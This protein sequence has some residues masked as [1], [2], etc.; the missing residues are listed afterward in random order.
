[1]SPSPV[2]STPILRTALVWSAIV[3]GV[4]AVILAVV[5]YLVGGTEGLWSGLL[6]VVLSAVF[7]AITAA[8]ILVANRWFGDAL[9]VPIFF[10]IV[11]GGWILKLVVFVVALLLLRGQ[12]WI[13]PPIFF[14]AVVTSVLASLAVDV[15][16][17]LRMRVPTV[18]GER[19][20]TAVAD[21]EAPVSRRRESGE[22]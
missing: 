21:D 18:S 3:A 5:G 10:G 4:L 15:V 6:G 16:V 22:A 12:P 20:P 11:L 2:T 9:Y 13:D 14:A 17:M 19:L 7:L 1:V 8:S